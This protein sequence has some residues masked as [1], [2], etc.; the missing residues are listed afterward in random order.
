MLVLSQIF[1]EQP[2]FSQPENFKKHAAHSN[3]YQLLADIFFISHDHS[4]LPDP[5]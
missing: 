2:D 3:L 1:R 4:P 5:P